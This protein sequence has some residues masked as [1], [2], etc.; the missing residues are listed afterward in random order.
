MAGIWSFRLNF[1]KNA[2]LNYYYSRNL[3]SF[4]FRGDNAIV[5][6]EF[7]WISIWRLVMPHANYC[8]DIL[9][10]RW[11]RPAFVEP[12]WLLR[13]TLSE[14]LVAVHVW[15]APDH[16]H[17]WRWQGCELLPCQANVKTGPLP[18]LY[19]LVFRPT[20]P[21]VSVDVVFLRF[22]ECFPVISGFCIAIQYRICY[23]LSTIFWVIASGLPSAK[24]SPGSN[25]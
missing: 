14:E 13:V 20:I 15:N 19:F 5:F 1:V 25:L 11:L 16:W 12:Y 9:K 4:N 23:C 10:A 2:C 17:N 21:L 8:V 24:F 18:S 6:N 3:V 22:S 7:S